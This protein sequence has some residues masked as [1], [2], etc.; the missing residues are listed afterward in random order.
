MLKLIKKEFVL[1]LHPTSVIFL[2]FSALVFVPNYPYEVIFF[3]SGLSVYFVCMASRENKDLSFTCALPVKKESVPLARILM[4]VILQCVLLLLTI[5]MG[6][7]KECILPADMQY[8]AVGISANI[9]LA[10]NG[11]L[12]LGCF[13]LV[14]F[15]LY[16][17]SPE[18]IGVPF[19]AAAALLF[20]LIGACV[21][22]RWTVPLFSEVLNGGNT[23]HFGAKF[24]A[25][26]V[27]VGIYAAFTAAACV[28]S[29]K[30]FRKIDL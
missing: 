20:L 28:L 27:G 15:P 30:A 12:I 11:A 16:Y 23:F 1:C 6:T 26:S 9:A 17:R 10:G 2:F 5:I 25:L 24:T 21:C 4:T 14:F 7:I 8:N 18:K 19:V 13:N 29:A 3:F 22:L